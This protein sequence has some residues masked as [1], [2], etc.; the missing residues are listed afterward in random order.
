MNEGNGLAIAAKNVAVKYDLRLRRRRTFRH[1]LAQMVRGDGAGKVGRDEFW[2]LRDVTF[3]LPRGE[4]LLVMGPNGSGK[5]TLLLTI[6][7]ILRPDA[8]AITTY[9]SSATLLSLGQ[10]F[11]HDLTGRENIYLNAAY[12][13]F[14]REA[15]D[16]RF[17]EIAAFSELGRFIEAPVAIYSA[18]M[19][20]RLGFS[21]A[22]HLEPQILLLD[23]ILGVGDPGFREKSQLRLKELATSAEA[24]VIVSHS[25]RFVGAVATKALWLEEGSVRAFGDPEEILERYQQAAKSARLAVRGDA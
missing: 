11:E 3:A 6:A 17:S 4:V 25:A 20:A 21:I 22:V 13:G 18:G 15:I 1:T 24:V 23:E 2:A 16:E 14:K 7:G 8:G 12:L 9:G 5:S 10:G 19:R